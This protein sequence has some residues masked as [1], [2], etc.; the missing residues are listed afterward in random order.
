MSEP[1]RRFP[2]LRLAVAAAV[3]A[4]GAVL[5]R[6]LDLDRVLDALRRADLR[7]VAAAALLN[8]TLNTAARVGRWAPLLEA[9]PRRGR[10]ARFLEL[11][12]L[13]VAA[14][15]ASNLLPARGGEAL[16]VAQLHRRH[17]YPV[18]GL[19]A[20]QLVEAVVAALSLGFLAVLIVPA[21]ATPRSLSAALLTFAALGGAGAGL[22]LWLARRAPSGEAAATGTGLLARAR[23]ALSRLADAARYLRGGRTWARSLL[24]SLASDLTDVA[25]IG[26]TLAAVGVQLSPVGWV[27]AF[28]ALNLVLILPSTPA[29]VGV[30]EMGA[31]AAL[32][33]LG[34][35]D[36]P[37]L[38]FA[39]LY[40]AAHVVPPTVVGGVLLVTL[41][42]RKGT[43]DEASA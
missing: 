28:V 40:H 41:D 10:G 19:I 15:A 39:L 12:A 17:G 31:V 42:L 9:L 11:A 5:L 3:L 18:A 33:A 2:W 37:A 32:H 16:R 22:T 38:A 13:F 34:V 43:A 21:P 36:E 35:A 4:L 14:Q 24:W 7:L 1:R 20:V 29:Q 23:A 26:L 25:M 30:L 27:V 8:L 6:R